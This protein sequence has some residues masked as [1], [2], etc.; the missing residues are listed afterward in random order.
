MAA[1]RRS[2]LLVCRGEAFHAFRH[3][4]GRRFERVCGA[5]EHRHPARQVFDAFLANQHL[6]AAQVRP[7]GPF[8]RDD[9]DPYL[10]RVGDMGATAQL[11]R[12]L[13]H[14]YDADEVSILLPEDGHGADRSSEIETRL[15]RPNR[16]VQERSLEHL[17]P[18]VLHLRITQR[19]VVIEVEPQAT[20]LNEGTRLARVISES[21]AEDPMQDV[22]RRVGP[23][24]A[25]AGR[26][27]RPRPG[28]RRRPRSSPSSTTTR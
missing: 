22:R 25:R 20:R 11:L 28:P 19:V 15:V 16:V 12:V 8:A 23:L 21:V 10:A 13:P 4:L 5:L 18:D 7:H 6:D 27:D 24:A 2:N 9:G 14:L 3:V 17:R 26:R 1:S